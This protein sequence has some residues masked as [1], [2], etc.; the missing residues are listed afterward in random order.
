MHSV[1]LF[2]AIELPSI[3]YFEHPV[4]TVLGRANYGNHFFAFQGC[5]VGVNYEKDGSISR[6]SIGENVLMLANSSI[7]GRSTIGNN[8]IISSGCQ[9]INTD[10]PDNSIVFNQSKELIVKQLNSDTI[11]DRIRMI[12]HFSY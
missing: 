11:K 10:V 1:E 2:Y 12:T 4:G 6:P 3:F 5:T 9:I 8:V 7:I